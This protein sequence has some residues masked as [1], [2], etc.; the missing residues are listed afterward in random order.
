[1]QKFLRFH[2]LRYAVSVLAVSIASFAAT[3]LWSMLALRVTPLFFAAVAISAWY[4][5]RGPGL[6]ATVLSALSFNYFFTPPYYALSTSTA[7]L[8]QVGAFTLVALLIS[9][10]TKGRERAER[11]ASRSEARLSATL[12]SIGDAVIATDTQGRVT[13]MNPVAQALTGWKE[14]EAVGQELKEVF[15]IINEQTRQTVENPVTRVLR[16]GGMVGLANHTVLIAKDGTER[17][18]EDSGA[19]ITDVNEKVI[20]VVLVFRDVTERRRAEAAIRESQ[21][22]LSLAQ[23][24]AHIGTWEWEPQT[25]KAFWSRERYEIFGIEPSEPMFFDKW[26][27]AIHPEDLPVVQ[28]TIE[29]CLATGSAEAEYRYLH[30]SR[31]LRWILSKVGMVGPADNRRMTGISLDITERKRAEEERQ[32][33]LQREQEARKQAEAANRL[34]DEFL[35][36]VSHELRTP[37]TSIMGWANLLRTQKFDDATRARALETIERNAKVQTQLI[38]DLLD[39]SRI[40]TGQIRLQVHPVELAKV[41]EAAIE[42]VRPAAEAKG[43]RLQRVVDSMAGPVSGDPDRLQQV[44]WN[45]LSNAVKFTPKGGRIY[46][47]L[48]RSDS[49]A[50]ITVQDTGQGISPEFLPHVFDR[51]RQADSSMTRQHGGLGLGL[52]IVRHLVELHGG[53]VHA[54]SEGVDRGATFTINLPLMPISRPAQELETVHPAAKGFTSLDCQTDLEGVRVLVVD[55][56]PD[57]RD[58][59]GV[60]LKQ[61]GAEVTLAASA[62]EAL[63]AFRQ[64]KPDVLI[65][66]IQMPGKDGYALIREIREL[67]AGDG[68]QTPAAALTAHARVE[69]RVRSLSAGFQVHVPKPVEPVELIAVVSSLAGRR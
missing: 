56:E 52:A 30:P 31:G 15:K 18:I 40:I 55:D 47:K 10:I 42:A 17:P 12:R 51:F 43:I 20:G 57:A 2:L 4:G 21:E 14:K 35:A 44:V 22:R 33:L 62:D 11:A 64:I 5:G 29:Q 36:T 27:A 39:V 24:A 53:T 8:V 25:N 54:T 50:R 61:C 66:D 16:E 48:E 41:I 34:K 67:E 7:D 13:F 68:S 58:L 69:D 6:L 3:L 46:I 9:Y 65:S 38:E 63:Q 60:I 59:L 37:L 32:Q 49:Q 19:P 1:M 26:M 45:L 23:T 28:A